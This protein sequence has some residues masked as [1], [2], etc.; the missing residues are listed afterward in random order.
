MNIF[1]ITV[2]LEYIEPPIRRRLE[3]P[4]DIRLGRL[5]R[6]LQAAMGW[7]D[8]HLHAFHIGDAVYGVPDPD[9]PD[10]T[11]NERNVRLDRVAGPGDRLHYEY[12]FGDGWLHNI[13][14]ETTHPADPTI[15]YPR[16]IEGARAC[17]PEDCGGPP[18]YAELIEALADARHPD[19][20]RASIPRRSTWPRP[21]KNCG[22]CAPCSWPGTRP[23]QSWPRPTGNCGACAD[24]SMAR[25]ASDPWNGRNH[26]RLGQAAKL[27]TQQ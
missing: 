19:Q 21:T 12:D 9:F 7:A 3:I 6:V 24:S 17:P 8:S 11:E 5:H 14:I 2:T 20:A 18:G 13:V 16:C 22:A 26:G 15:H 10:H 4:A 23:N 25:A 1:Q 27:R